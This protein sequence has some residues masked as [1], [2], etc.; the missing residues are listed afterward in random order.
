MNHHAAG[1]SASRKEER[2]KMRYRLTNQKAMR[3]EFWTSFPE[4]NRKRV[5]DFGGKGKMY[6]CDTRCAFVDFVAQLQINGE[7]SEALAYRATLE[8]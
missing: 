2:K 6:V 8:A 3:C 4:L 7:I 5:V 1:A